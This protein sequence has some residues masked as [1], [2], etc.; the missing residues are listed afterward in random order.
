MCCLNLDR[1]YGSSSSVRLGPNVFD[2]LAPKVLLPGRT[3]LPLRLYDLFAAY[4]SKLLSL[5]TD[6]RLSLLLLPSTRIR[7]IGGLI[8]KDIVFGAVVGV[9]GD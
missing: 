4:R 3:P 7:E 6:L 1:S 9:V 5:T 8:D 2:E